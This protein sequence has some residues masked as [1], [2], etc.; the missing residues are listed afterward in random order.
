MDSCIIWDICMPCTHIFMNIYIWGNSG[1]QNFK[2]KGFWER[3][4]YLIGSLCKSKVIFSQ[5][6]TKYIL[7]LSVLSLWIN[8][9]GWCL[10]LLSW[11]PLACGTP[12]SCDVL[13]VKHRDPQAWR[14]HRRFMKSAAALQ[15]GD[16]AASFVSLVSIKPSPHSRLIWVM[17]IVLMVLR[18]GIVYYY[19]Y[20]FWDI[21]IY[22]FMPGIK[23]QCF[24]LELN[25]MLSFS[26]MSLCPFDF[27]PVAVT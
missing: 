8:Q 15:E 16:P 2:K 22:I 17:G 18:S 27:S 12:G 11:K 7:C 1:Q 23:L 5:K 19:H 21:S 6:R 3:E 24:Q 14:W 4:K 10:N 26:W 25:W 20:Y 13:R 9:C